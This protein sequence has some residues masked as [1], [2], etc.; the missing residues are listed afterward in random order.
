[1]NIQQRLISS[2]TWPSSSYLDYR[3]AYHD[4]HFKM[5]SRYTFKAHIIEPR[6]GLKKNSFRNLLYQL[7]F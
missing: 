4:P 6:G 5:C 2:R 1:M 7:V 3:T